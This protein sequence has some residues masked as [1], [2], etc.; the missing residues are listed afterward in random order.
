MS[1][2]IMQIFDCAKR[3]TI[4]SPTASIYGVSLSG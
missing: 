1:A 2:K 4:F 3:M